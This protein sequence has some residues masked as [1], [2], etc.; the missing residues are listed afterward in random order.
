MLADLGVVDLRDAGGSWAAVG[1]PNRTHWPGGWLVCAPRGMR[2]SRLIYRRTWAS[3]S[4]EQD[5]R[6]GILND[7]HRT[8]AQRQTS[9][10]ACQVPEVRVPW[11][12]RLKYVIC[13]DSG[14]TVKA[15]F[16]WACAPHW[17]DAMP[18]SDA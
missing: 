10:F 13:C 5:L 16:A 17:L 9:G 2:G 6:R 18:G 12:Y 8:I 1:L 14:V 3:A 15:A 7:D 11:I 4:L